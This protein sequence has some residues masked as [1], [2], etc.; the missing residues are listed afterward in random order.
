[1][2][3]GVFVYNVLLKNTT[4]PGS[5]IYGGSWIGPPLQVLDFNNQTYAAMVLIQ[6]TGLA[7]SPSPT[8]TSV[9]TS[10][11]TSTKTGTIVGGVVGGVTFIAI[12]TGLIL[13][14]LCKRKQSR[15]GPS[16][17]LASSTPS[18]FII[19]HPPSIYGITPFILPEPWEMDIAPKPAKAIISHS[20]IHPAMDELW[21]RVAGWLSLCQRPVLS[22]SLA[23]TSRSHVSPPS[24]WQTHFVVAVARLSYIR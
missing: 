7:P 4:Y 20:N 18:V 8:V 1:M 23:V 14:F 15:Q 19:S 24:Y 21:S 22:K 11:F 17:I 16:S 6:A 3:G 5:K 2:L 13:L 12:V 10:G 9:N